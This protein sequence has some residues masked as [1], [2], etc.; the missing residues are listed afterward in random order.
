MI[1]SPRVLPIVNVTLLNAAGTVQFQDGTINL[2]IPVT[3][4]AGVAIGPLSP[5]KSVSHLG[6][7]VLSYMITGRGGRVVASV[8]AR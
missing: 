4:I 8:G 2:G 5:L 3:V 7:G 6:H 1:L